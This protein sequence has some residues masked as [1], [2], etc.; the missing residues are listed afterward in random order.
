MHSNRYIQE[1]QTRFKNNISE[2][3]VYTRALA[4]YN[5]VIGD[6]LATL[7]I[8]HVRLEYYQHRSQNCSTRLQELKDSKIRIVV[9][10]LQLRR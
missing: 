1:L 6:I 9:A 5:E 3:E 7:P 8:D 2:K 10:L 4:H